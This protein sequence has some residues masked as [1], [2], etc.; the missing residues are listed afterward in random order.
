MAAETFS[1]FIS[2]DA[3]QKSRFSGS[4]QLQE[5]DKAGFDGAEVKVLFCGLFHECE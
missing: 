2:G 4:S 3:Q 5:G 1:S